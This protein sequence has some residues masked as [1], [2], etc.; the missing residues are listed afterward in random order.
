[1]HYGRNF[2]AIFRI[3][4]SC[5]NLAKCIL[6]ASRYLPVMVQERKI[7]FPP[8]SSFESIRLHTTWFLH[9]T[10]FIQLLSNHIYCSQVFQRE[11]TQGIIDVNNLIESGNDLVY[12]RESIPGASAIKL[13]LEK[14]KSR[15]ESIESQAATR[16]Q[17]LEDTIVKV[18]QSNVQRILIWIE[19]KEKLLG[20][21]DAMISVDDLD[22]I[23]KVFF[24]LLQLL[25]FLDGTKLQNRS[26][27][28]I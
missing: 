20:S 7:L 11:L 16:D 8:I 17:E 18:F 4:T 10:F 28:V 2:P 27:E 26:L 24:F 22:V 21:M 9:L 13:Q 25:Q 14:T 12:G 23:V 5:L 3:K 1:M 15:W 19:E 6:Y